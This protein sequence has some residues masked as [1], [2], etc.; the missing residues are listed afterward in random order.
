MTTLTLQTNYATE[1]AY[2]IIQ[3]Q[4]RN[5]KVKGIVNKGYSFSIMTSWGE[6]S[7][8]TQNNT[9]NMSYKV[10]VKAIVLLILFWELLF[11]FILGYMEYQTVKELEQEVTNIL[12]NA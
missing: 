4:L 2:Q 11:P 3:S 12:N 5:P 9:L 1:R 10:S 8:A 6:I 7:I